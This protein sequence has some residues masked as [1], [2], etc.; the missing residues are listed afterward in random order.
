MSPPR[1]TRPRRP[2]RGVGDRNRGARPTRSPAPEAAAP[3]TVRRSPAPAATVA[4]EV[5]LAP[6]LDDLVL[7]ELRELARRARLPTPVTTRRDDALEVAWPGDPAQLHALRSAQSVARV[8]RF[9]VPRPKAL[10]DNTAQR[11]LGEGL[12]AIAAAAPFGALRFSAAGSGSAVMRRLSEALAASVGLPLDE[13]TGDLVVRV[14]PG[15]QGGWEVLART[16]PR[17]LSV[18]PWR[19][20]DRPGALDAALA[21]ALVRLAGVRA[22]DRVVNPMAGSGTLLIERALAGPAACLHGVEHDPAALACAERNAA[23]AGV[24]ERLRLV[25]GDARGT[26][27]A[28]VADGPAGSGAAPRRRYDLVL[29]DPPWGDAVGDHAANQG[30][31]AALLDAAAAQTVTGGRMLLVTHEVRLT[32]RLLAGHPVWAVRHARRVW[33]GGHR[34]L[35]VLLERL[36]GALSAD[37]DAADAC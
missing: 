13:R 20:C 7:H 22:E 12:R 23:A 31:Y 6:G 34:P 37:G 25:R 1:R 2:R 36:P 19:V 14:R 35:C 32:E 26:W 3:E 24:A 4:C 5:A 9:D 28:S 21:A 29:V 16:T 33:Q 11:T 8:W 17:P 18:R 15:A 27:D 10:L 30:L